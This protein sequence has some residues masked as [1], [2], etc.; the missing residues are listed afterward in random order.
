MSTEGGQSGL[1]DRV[2]QAHAQ[3]KSVLDHLI[4]VS[5]SNWRQWAGVVRPREALP[6]L[7]GPGA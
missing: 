3:P 2:A 6:R 1:G 4:S 5:V 7:P